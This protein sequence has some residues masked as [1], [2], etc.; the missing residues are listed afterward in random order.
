MSLSFL[1]CCCTEEF[2]VS[3]IW[4]FTSGEVIGGLTHTY[5]R[6]VRKCQMIRLW[7]SEAVPI[8]VV[9]PRWW[10]A[11]SK[12]LSA[13][14]LSTV[15]LSAKQWHCIR[16]LLGHI[17]HCGNW[18]KSQVAVNSQFAHEYEKPTVSK[19]RHSPSFCLCIWTNTLS[20]CTF[21]KPG[22]FT[23]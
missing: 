4:C 16:L 9:N 8:S 7:N 10:F 2:D 14:Q 23:R 21:I 1:G 11:S 22:L 5:K 6:Y 13:H 3:K 15:L 20:H 17:L 12:H 19:V 18:G